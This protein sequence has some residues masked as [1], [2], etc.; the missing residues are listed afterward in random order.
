MKIAGN[1]GKRTPG[2]QQ[3]QKK[4]QSPRPGQK[5]PQQSGRQQQSKP[6]VKRLNTAKGTFTFTMVADGC[7][8]EHQWGNNSGH[9]GIPS[10]S[11]PGFVAM[12]TALHGNAVGKVRARAR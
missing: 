6:G 4:G 1:K 3:T 10:M 2:K 5:K 11:I 7:Y 9:I 12:L 8:I